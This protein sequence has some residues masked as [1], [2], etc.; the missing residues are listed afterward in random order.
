MPKPLI[1]LNADYRGPKQDAPAFSF[2]SSE[3]YDAVQKAADQLTGRG[4]AVDVVTF[5]APQIWQL[6]ERADSQ[7]L[8]DKTSALQFP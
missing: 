4:N 3:Y 8:V 5:V 1:G 6:S 2:V 7:D